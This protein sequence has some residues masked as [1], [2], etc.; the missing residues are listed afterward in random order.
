[1]GVQVGPR[2]RDSRVHPEGKALLS[3][4]GFPRQDRMEIRVTGGE[5]GRGFREDEGARLGSPEEE[6]GINH[7]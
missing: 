6:A 3:P 7:H 5:A 2:V 1:M 4:W